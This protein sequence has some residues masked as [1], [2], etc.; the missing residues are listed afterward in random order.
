MMFGLAGA[1]TVGAGTGAFRFG[2]AFQFK[3]ALNPLKDGDK[4]VPL[5][6]A[7]AAD[8]K[9]RSGSLF[10]LDTG[11][12]VELSDVRLFRKDPRRPANLRP[13]AFTT[14]FKLKKGAKL[15]EERIYRLN[16]VDGG[17][18]DLFLSVAEPR[19]GRELYAVFN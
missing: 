13:E 4:N 3:K 2:G 1:T 6:Q 7:G 9:A 16:H 10:T 18:I 15:L 14:S 5:T 17:A 12:I 8:W 11:A 19:G